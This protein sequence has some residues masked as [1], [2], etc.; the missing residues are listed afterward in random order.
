MGVFSIVFNYKFRNNILFNLRTIIYI[1]N[2]QARFISEIK[3]IL[4]R[5]YINLYT[6]KI[7]SFSIAIIIINNFKGKK[8]ILFTGAAYIPS[9]YTNLIYI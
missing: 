7:V 3:S 5:I 4:D 8:K 9:F 1:F 2:D 6:K